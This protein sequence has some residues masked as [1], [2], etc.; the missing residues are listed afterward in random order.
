MNVYN[1]ARHMKMNVCVC[2]ICVCEICACET[3]VNGIDSM[4]VCNKCE[5]ASG[6]VENEKGLN[7]SARIK[8]IETHAFRKCSFKKVYYTIFRKFW[9]FRSLAG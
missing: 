3:R 1:G 4:R 5:R 8:G 7:Y 9:I 6:S 2:E